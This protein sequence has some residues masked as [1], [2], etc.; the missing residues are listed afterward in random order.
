MAEL[1]LQMLGT[2]RRLRRVHQAKAES[3]WTQDLEVD[4]LN[5]ENHKHFTALVSETPTLAPA[6]FEMVFISKSLER[7]DDHAVGSK[8]IVFMATSKEIRRQ[9]IQKVL[10]E[11][12]LAVE[13]NEGG[14]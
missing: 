10:S 2:P 3:I 11:E 4:K 8:E 5:K 12:K 9:G 6:I 1:T 14:P 13:Q 7:I